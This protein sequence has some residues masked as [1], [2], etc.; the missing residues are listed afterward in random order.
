MKL[1]TECTE[2][3]VMTLGI[4]RQADEQRAAEE[5]FELIHRD[6]A[7]MVLFY[8]SSRYDLPRLAEAMKLRFGDRVVGCTTAGEICRYGF[9]EHS[10]TGVCLSSKVVRIRSGVLSR[11][12]HRPF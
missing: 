9:T 8:S 1:L 5:L 6:D 7:E 11:I 4:S 12:F 3:G 10:L 2:N